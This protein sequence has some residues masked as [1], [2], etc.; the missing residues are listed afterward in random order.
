M[1]EITIR[2]VGDFTIPNCVWKQELDDVFTSIS[3]ATRREEKERFLYGHKST[4]LSL[5]TAL[6]VLVGEPFAGDYHCTGDLFCA[7]G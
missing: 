5:S 4:P 1:V 3:R 7:E 2:L 6:A